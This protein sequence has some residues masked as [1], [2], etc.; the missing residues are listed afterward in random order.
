MVVEM[1]RVMYLASLDISIASVHG[2]E[3]LAQD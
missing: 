3:D 1:G 2:Y